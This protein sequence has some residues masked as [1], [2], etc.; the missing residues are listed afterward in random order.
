MKRKSSTTAPAGLL[1]VHGGADRLFS[2][3]TR[4]AKG[5]RGANSSSTPLERLNVKLEDV[6][7]HAR[8]TYPLDSAFLEKMV[9][10]EILN[11]WIEALQ[12]GRS[13]LIAGGV[14]NNRGV[15]TRF[16]KY[17]YKDDAFLVDS[18]GSVKELLD[19]L[20]KDLLGKDPKD[21]KSSHLSLPLYTSDVAGV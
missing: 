4:G 16:S 5:L 17:L 10:L 13:V 6:N 1:A 2:S 3:Q 21:I 19:I 7:Q 8:R 9:P 15:L 14:G 18:S 20:V 11:N 12:A